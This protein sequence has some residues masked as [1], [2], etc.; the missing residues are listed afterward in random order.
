MYYPEDSFDPPQMVYGVD[1]SGNSDVVGNRQN[2]AHSMGH[3]P[4]PMYIPQHMLSMPSSAYMS[5][6]S[7]SHQLHMP[8]M[9][10]HGHLQSSSGPSLR[11]STEIST[12]PYTQ[13][14]GA[15]I[16]HRNA[17]VFHPAQPQ[18]AQHGLN[19]S[20]GPSSVAS[21]SQP[22]VHV[23]LS[24]GS[25]SS[26]WAWPPPMATKAPSMPSQH[27]HMNS[28]NQSTSSSI[29]HAHS[30]SSVGSKSSMPL[31]SGAWAGPTPRS[32]LSSSGPSVNDARFRPPISSSNSGQAKY[33]PGNSTASMSG[34]VMGSA[35]SRTPAPKSVASFVASNAK[36]NYYN[37]TPSNALGSSGPMSSSVSGANVPGGSGSSG[38]ASFSD[39]SVYVPSSHSNSMHASSQHLTSSHHQFS[40]PNPMEEYIA[41][42]LKRRQAKLQKD[43]PSSSPSTP[44]PGNTANAAASGVVGR[45][46]SPATGKDGNK[47]NPVLSSPSKSGSISG[48]NG[49]SNS[50]SMSQ[51]GGNGS[52]GAVSLTDTTNWQ[53]LDLSG[54]SL[55]VVS[56]QVANYSQ[57]SVLYLQHNRLI[58]LPVE[59]CTLQA[60]K[61]LDLSHNLLAWLPAEI[62][63]LLNLKELILNGNQLRSLPVEVGKLFRLNELLIDDNP[64]TDIPIDILTGGAGA[65][66][67]HLRTMLAPSEP[68]PPRAWVLSA[69]ADRSLALPGYFQGLDAALGP[70]AVRT[71]ENGHKQ[72]S[73]QSKDVAKFRIE[74]SIR[75]MTYNILADI[76]ASSLNYC[77]SWALNWNH[78]KNVVLKEIDTYSPDL[79]CLQEVVWAHYLQLFAPELEARGYKGVFHPKTRVKYSADLN[80]VDGCASFYRAS[81]FEEVDSFN[82]EF[83][84]IAQDNPDRYC[85]MG[86]DAGYIR[87]CSKDNIAVGVILRRKDRVA[88]LQ[89]LQQQQR[90]A[91]QSTIVGGNRA[92]GSNRRGQNNASPQP[93]QQT[94]AGNL[95]NLPFPSPEEDM[96]ML[97]NTHI[98]WDPD[99]SDVK[100]MQV[101]ILL[102]QL[103]AWVDE[104]STPTYRM[105][106]ILGGD[107]N[108][109][110]DSG[111]YQLLVEGYLPGSHPDFLGYTYG[112]YTDSGLKHSFSLHSA[113][114]A[115]AGEP[116]FTNYTGDFN[117]V[118]DYIWYTG[119]CLNVERALLGV[120]ESVV[121]AYNG[122][123]PNP[124]M[125]SDHIPLVSDFV[126]NM[127]RRG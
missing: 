57:I 113:N 23:P 41:A 29:S 75:T 122:A 64:I 89:Q 110:P 91:Q 61:F 92:S 5:N 108:S 72:V 96:L 8:S 11:T 107:F 124:H 30:I 36:M 63:Q 16:T 88:A 87:L 10:V 84:T 12:L 52:N 76:Y 18:Q 38:V 78:R 100:L 26:Q 127:N 13:N 106:L 114:A 67:S 1:N 70:K 112:D 14:Q 68:P 37:Y 73:I 103:E 102:E 118:L 79:L 98:H 43:A 65:I 20:S 2:M 21:S 22:R 35:S 69:A 90:M 62:G 27:P 116:P 126:Q 71:L 45:T 25:M 24:T 60:L 82:I 56:P 77:P 80:R 9:N 117:G 4:T 7:S 19:T 46:S 111:V 101:Q 34:N 81:M 55:S 28:A 109:M 59:L 119:D 54:M 94:L 48:G 104:Y 99:F 15:S 53:V 123:L 66:V 120:D 44:V 50:S 115:I 95:N 3:H 83:Q 33:L 17:P 31:T 93:M 86:D 105:P 125:P 47:Q 97:V 85:S 121:H 39:A 32:L 74:G 42:S 6:V 40:R 58:S 51:L 49:M